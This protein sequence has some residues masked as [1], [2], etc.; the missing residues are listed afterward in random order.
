LV[1]LLEAGEAV[2]GVGVVA[3]GV[4]VGVSPFL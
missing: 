2:V 3:D 1:L 4:A